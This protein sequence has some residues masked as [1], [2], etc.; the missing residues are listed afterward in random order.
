[1]VVS[2]KITDVYARKV[3]K[4]VGIF[5]LL[6][7]L[8]V[9]VVVQSYRMAK[10]LSLD[11][12]QTRLSQGLNNFESQILRANQITKVLQQDAIFYN[13]LLLEAEPDSPDYPDFKQLQ[14]KLALWS[15]TVEMMEDSYILYRNNDLF[16]SNQL[17]AE[18]YRKVYPQF[19][20]L[21]E[22]SVEEWRNSMF[23]ENHYFRLLSAASVY[24]SYHFPTEYQAIPLVIN[25]SYSSNVSNSVLVFLFDQE[26]VINSMLAEKEQEVCR[27]TLEC[28]D[29]LI[30]STEAHPEPENNICITETSENG[31][32]EATL[33]IPKTYFYGKIRSVVNILILY[34]TI[35]LALILTLLGGLLLMES[36]RAGKM[37]RAVSQRTGLSFGKSN[38]YDFITNAMDMIYRTSEERQQSIKRMT[39]HIRK[40]ATEN[41]LQFGVIPNAVS[42]EDS[43]YFQSLFRSCCVIAA[44]L[45]STDT[46]EALLHLKVF[47]SVLHK[48]SAVL[49]IGFN[50][51]CCVLP[52]EGEAVPNA[53][54][55][56]LKRYAEQTGFVRFGVSLPFSGA[57]QAHEAYRQ[58][59]SALSSGE[60]QNGAAM[61]AF[62]KTSRGAFELSAQIRLHDAIIAGDSDGVRRIFLSFS[63]ENSTQE[64]KQ[65][66]FYTISHTIQEAS[67]EMEREQ[68]FVTGEQPA[69]PWF[70]DSLPFPDLLD[71]LRDFSLRLC[72]LRSER[73]SRKKSRHTGQ[74]MQY[75]QEHFSDP[76][77]S[78]DTAA[79]ALAV[80]ANTVFSVVREETGK[81][82]GNYVEELRLARAEQ[83]LLTTDLPGARIW[84]LCGFGSEKTFYRAFSKKHGVPPNQWKNSAKKQ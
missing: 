8:L 42:A 9:P 72:A 71:S 31:F 20:Q 47:F 78:A 44:E 26:Q 50:L 19:F 75:V 81:T 65:M 54:L 74:V 10:Q 33:E 25:A 34:V 4:Y 24:S 63:P 70:N 41:L 61:Y 45:S 40:T 84:E 5:C 16:L 51:M 76:N 35:G 66:L 56:E 55:G 60:T 11:T 15:L 43:A 22:Q 82:L 58:A 27:L 3:K 37:L 68:L 7:L 32:L 2:M 69:P 28:A 73:K 77:F 14:E 83:L 59:R 38:E 23:M 13:L 18:D 79:A 49:V 67:R 62:S 46:E 39:S 17:A 57:E 52:L 48:D 6:L 29:S 53:L 21:E 1:M 80:S 12:F 36:R 30:F 64:E